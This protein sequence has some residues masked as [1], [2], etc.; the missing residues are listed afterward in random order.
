MPMG[1]NTFHSVLFSDLYHG[2]VL[3]GIK[4]DCVH[5]PKRELHVFKKRTVQFQSSL[6]VWDVHNKASS[7]ASSPCRTLQSFA[8]M[9]S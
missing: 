1:N 5:I 2:F 7:S 6:G 4:N 9:P 3:D 8:I